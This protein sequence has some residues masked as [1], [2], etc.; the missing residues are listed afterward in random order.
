[1]E[2]FISDKKLQY[3]VEEDGLRG[4]YGADMAKKI[5]MRLAAFGPAESL[6]DFWPPKSGPER[7]QELI[8]EL[9]GNFP[10]T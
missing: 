2:L 6:G 3:A 9:A 1:M 5:A 4:R 10:L 7:C 8:G